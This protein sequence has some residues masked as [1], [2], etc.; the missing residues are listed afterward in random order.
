MKDWNNS[1]MDEGRHKIILTLSVLT[2]FG[3]T[4]LL[5]CMFT[6]IMYLI[7]K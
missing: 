4:T 6:F 3:I 5:A 7:L 1:N 2:A